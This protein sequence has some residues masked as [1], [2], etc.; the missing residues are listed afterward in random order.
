MRVD[1][2]GGLLDNLSGRGLGRIMGRES[3]EG[4]IKGEG[5][6]GDLRD[7]YGFLPISVIDLAHKNE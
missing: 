4:W 3:R 1:A 7:K 5:E 6:R 2:K